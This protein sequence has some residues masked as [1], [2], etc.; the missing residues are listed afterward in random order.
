M[1][2]SRTVEHYNNAIHYINNHSSVKSK[3]W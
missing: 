2:F 3:T 1:T